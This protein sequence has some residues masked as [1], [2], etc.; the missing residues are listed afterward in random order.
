MIARSRLIVKHYFAASSC[1]A[2]GA[3][4][5]LR[6]AAIFVVRALPDDAEAQDEPSDPAFALCNTNQDAADSG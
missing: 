4:S 6:L 5:G 3:A 2:S 1:T